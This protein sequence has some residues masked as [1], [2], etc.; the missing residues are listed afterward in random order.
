MA[1]QDITHPEDL[2]EDLAGLD[3]LLAGDSGT[4]TGE[5]RYL[6]KDGEIVWVNLTASLVRTPD[7]APDY[8][9][10]VIDDITARKRADI[11]LAESRSRLV[12]VVDSAMDAIIS[13]DSR[14]NIVH[15]NGAAEKM[16]QRKA[17]DVIGQPLGALLPQRF[18]AAHAQHI[19]A[20]GKTGVSN[21]TMGSLGTLSAIR[22]DGTEFPI[23]A[24]IS[25][26]SAGGQKLFTAILRDITERKRAEATQRLLLAELDHR[27]KNTLAT[28]QAITLQTLNA[29]TDP[30]EFVESF[31]GRIQA[32]GRAHGLLTRTGWQG[33]DL[34]T[35]IGEQLTL[36]P[37]SSDGR[38]TCTGPQIL[39]E[40]Q[41]A[42]HLGLVL[43]EL[44]SN[45][46]KYGSLSQREGR[47]TTEW[48]LNGE[49]ENPNLRL[50][51]TES[52]GPPVRAPI[53]RGFGAT[54][55]E[56]SLRYALGGEARLGFAP[57]GVTCDIMLPLPQRGRGAYGAKIPE[58]TR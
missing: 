21:R 52:N 39:L 46:R 34:A 50:R 10:R 54:L 47:L 51:W 13:V 8:F 27:V 58:G 45:A 44:G 14:Q 35:L 29:A 20:F 22:A 43:H 15:F 3:R 16:F 9:V 48:W 25:Q 4:Y 30:A 36:G 41:A 42:L 11:A 5:K 6:R 12:G 28:V 24:S 33:A 26:T 2:A 31:N 57:R 18:G 49:P 53:K 23:E 7:G 38:I 55:I 17:A 19:E 40:A 56:R 32:L 1:F 37:A